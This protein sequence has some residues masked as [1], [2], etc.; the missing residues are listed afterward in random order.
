MKVVVA[1]DCMGGYNSV[2]DYFRVAEYSHQSVRVQL[3]EYFNGLLLYFPLLPSICD[4]KVVPWF[5]CGVQESGLE[6]NDD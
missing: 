2:Q 3:E 1:L 5:E 6:N 4:T